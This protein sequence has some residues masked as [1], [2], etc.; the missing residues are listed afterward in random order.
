MSAL[1]H[2]PVENKYKE[3]LR[4]KVKTGRILS[5]LMQTSSLISSTT[6]IDTEFKLKKSTGYNKYQRWF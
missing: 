1:Q 4:Q 6:L 3:F 5:D 2:L